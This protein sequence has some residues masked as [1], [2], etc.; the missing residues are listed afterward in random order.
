MFG[1]WYEEQ[2]MSH[3][4]AREDIYNYFKIPKTE[5]EKH[6]NKDDVLK[7]I[8]QEVIPDTLDMC[9]YRGYNTFQRRE[10][11]EKVDT[12]LKR[13]YNKHTKSA[14]TTRHE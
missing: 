1:P 6:P 11:I 14:A 4:A 10:F 5:M 3:Q 9:S 7:R 13:A 8:I 2:E 12:Q